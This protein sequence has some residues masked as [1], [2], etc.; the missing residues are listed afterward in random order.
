[1]LYPKAAPSISTRIWEG[2]NRHEG[3]VGF[4]HSVLSLL[5]RADEVIE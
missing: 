1:L 4:A 5:A 2:R 3:F